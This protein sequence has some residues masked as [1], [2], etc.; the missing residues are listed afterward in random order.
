MMVNR[1]SRFGARWARARFLIILLVTPS[2][3]SI[4]MQRIAPRRMGPCDHGF[5]DGHISG[6]YRRRVVEG[7]DRAQACGTAS[8]IFDAEVGA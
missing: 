8:A 6:R 1:C 7:P 3:V 5:P 4:R 2:R